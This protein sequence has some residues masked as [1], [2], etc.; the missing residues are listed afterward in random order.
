[1]TGGVAVSGLEMAQNRGLIPWSRQQVLDKLEGIMESIYEETTSAAREYDTTL[2]DGANIASF[3]RVAE[4][5]LE[6]GTV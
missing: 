3:I 2:V 6:Q 4:A 1:M 5:V